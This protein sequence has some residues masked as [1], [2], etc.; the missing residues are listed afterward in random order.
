VADC[1]AMHDVYR[2]DF[3]AGSTIIPYC[4]PTIDWEPST[5]VLDELGIAPEKFMVIAGRLNPENNID[6]GADAIAASDLDLP[7]VVL[8]AANYESPVTGRLD[9]LARRDERIRVVGHVGSRQA[10]FDLLHHAAV[11]LHGHSVGGI[12]P[13]IVEAM[14]VGARVVAFDTEFNREVL[15]ADPDVFV[16]DPPDVADVVGTV[17]AEDASTQQAAR[18]R[19]AARI[20]SLYPVDAVVDAYEAVLQE[21]AGQ[22]RRRGL[23]VDTA[24]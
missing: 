10:F 16:L 6:R 7:L 17:L 22:G 24:W 18:D 19:A 1:R 13:S 3:G 23:V 20:A 2:D 11:Y 5:A 21:A 4:A 9:E 15:G 14:S 12:N 8:G